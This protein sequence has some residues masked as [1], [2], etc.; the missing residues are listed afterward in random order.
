MIKEQVT[1]DEALSFL[2]ELIQLDANAIAAL[3]ANRVPCNEQLANHPTAQCAAQH[4]GYHIGM[5]G[6]INGMFGVHEEVGVEDWGPITFVFRDHNLVGVQRL[7]G[8]SAS[9]QEALC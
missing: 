2:N 8:T 1:L 3:I 4:G 5:L 9:G 7:V 6:I